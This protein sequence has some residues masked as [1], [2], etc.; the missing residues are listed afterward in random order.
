VKYHFRRILLRLQRQLKTFW[1]S[2]SI[3]VLMDRPGE[4]R[5]P[6]SRSTRPLAPEVQL[7]SAMYR[8]EA[9]E[10]MNN[11]SEKLA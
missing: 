2:I 3:S 1:P 11:P 7:Q 10:A 5:A 6:Q 8:P 4:V 9:I